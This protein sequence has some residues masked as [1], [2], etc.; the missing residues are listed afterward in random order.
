MNC[1]APDEV[2]SP[3]VIEITDWLLNKLKPDFDFNLFV[4]NASVEQW[5]NVCYR[6]SAIETG[7]ATAIIDLAC[8]S[9]WHLHHNVNDYGIQSTEIG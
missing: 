4:E 2:E 8:H 9:G 5:K 1:Y 3:K 7:T 6:D